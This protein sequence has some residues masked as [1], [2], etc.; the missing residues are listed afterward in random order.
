[1]ISDVIIIILSSICRPEI[2][3]PAAEL[4]LARTLTKPITQS[5]LF[6]AIA[7]AI[8]SDAS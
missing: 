5:E 2:G 1:M 3:S 7:H 8:G 4:R 6:N